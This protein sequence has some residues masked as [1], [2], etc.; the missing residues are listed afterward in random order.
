MDDFEDNFL[1][2]C[3]NPDVKNADNEWLGAVH[4]GG[5]V[6]GRV[7][8][9]NGPGAEE[10]LFSPTK[11]ELIQLVKHWT[12]IAFDIEYDWFL[13]Q[14]S[15]SSDCRQQT[16]A[17]CRI[18]RIASAVGEPDVKKAI[19]EISEELIKES[20]G[21]R[22]FLRGTSEERKALQEEIERRMRSTEG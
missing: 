22:V 10:I 11:H 2:D 6:I 20:E 13:Y 19:D 5:S 7:D 8:E 21:W 14:Q 1:R 12:R 15:G 16:F 18:N 9:V 4:A 17:W 3:R